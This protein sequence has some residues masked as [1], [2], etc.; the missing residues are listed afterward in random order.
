M[1]LF[2][3][4]VILLC[5]A[6]SYGNDALTMQELY[7]KANAAYAAQSYQD[8]Y[9]LLEALNDQAPENPEIN[10]LMGRCALELKRYD[11]AIADLNRILVADPDNPDVLASRG[12]ARKQ[13]K[14]FQGAK[15]DFEKA[16]NIKPDFRFASRMIQSLAS[17]G[18]APRRSISVTAFCHL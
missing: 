7:Q 16:L 2:S 13:L 10:F 3:I 11:E 18:G 17:S 1:K 14:D 6:A 4:A 5:A 12:F 9:P 8:A 15:A